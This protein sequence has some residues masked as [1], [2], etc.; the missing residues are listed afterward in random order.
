MLH[1]DSRDIAN[2]AHHL[3]REASST[4]RLGG[5]ASFV[6]MAEAAEVT[7]LRTVSMV[8]APATMSLGGAG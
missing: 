5:F 8:E 4:N 2:G 6:A 7:W 3:L 1:S